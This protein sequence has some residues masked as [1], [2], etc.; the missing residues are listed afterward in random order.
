MNTLI[1]AHDPALMDSRRITAASLDTVEG[2]ENISIEAIRRYDVVLMDLLLKKY[3]SLYRTS[4]SLA[5]S[6][7]LRSLSLVLAFQRSC[8]ELIDQ[9]RAYIIREAPSRTLG[10]ITNMNRNLGSLVVSLCYHGSVDEIIILCKSKPIKFP[11][12]QETSLFDKEMHLAFSSVLTFM[13]TMASD[14]EKNLLV[15]V[16]SNDTI[17]SSIH[18]LPYMITLY[19][20]IVD[21]YL[22]S[23]T[24]ST[25]KGRYITND[26]RK[27]YLNP[28]IDKIILRSRTYEDGLHS[29]TLGQLPH[30]KSLEAILDRPDLIDN[31]I[32]ARTYIK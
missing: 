3:I 9:M 8:R 30:V 12:P 15:N 17:V 31:L 27:R 26:P 32:H 2:L 14:H 6:D 21:F 1:Y 5:S 18:S 22:G 20:N 23:R 7:R 4:D 19:R 11:S 29:L 16:I 13:N 28:L 25:D 10:Y 24:I